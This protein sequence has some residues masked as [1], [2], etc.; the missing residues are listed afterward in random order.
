MKT[1]L[2][3]LFTGFCFLIGGF[4]TAIQV[5]IIV[6]LID[7]FSGIIKAVFNKEFSWQFGLMGIFKKVLIVGL[8]MLAYQI[9]RLIGVSDIS[10]FGA[11]IEG[12]IHN[13]IIV[14]LVANESLSIIDNCKKSGIRV[15][16][17]L[18][19]TIEKLTEDGENHEQL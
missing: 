13:S 11:R 4:D 6:I 5:L 9:E 8:V 3:S 12:F 1:F 10:L 17:K 19:D 16:Q 7:Y 15:P 18:T 2:F 14:M